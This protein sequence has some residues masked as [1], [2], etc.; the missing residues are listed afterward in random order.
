MIT[1]RHPLCLAFCTALCLLIPAANSVAA[2]NEPA[3]PVKQQ[4]EKMALDLKEIRNAL[5]T[6]NGLQLGLRLKGAEEEIL[7]LREQMLKLEAR[8]AQNEQRIQGTSERI[9]RSLDVSQE[10][11]TVRIIN[12][13]G[14]R[15]SV[16][17]NDSAYDVEAFQTV[18]IP[19]VRVGQVTYQVLVD[20]YGTIHT[21]TSNLLGGETRTLTINPPQ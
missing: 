10:T 3:D 7:T 19:G 14:I 13:S 5:D 21:R 6:L 18:N 12:R 15:A 4:L 1:M 16:F 2:E 9:A 17:L 8:V 20:G 11:A